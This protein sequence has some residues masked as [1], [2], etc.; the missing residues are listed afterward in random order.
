MTKESNINQLLESIV[1]VCIKQTGAQRGVLVTADD[2]L[3]VECIV[4]SAPQRTADT[5]RTLLSNSSSVCRE[6][7]R[8]V[9]RTRTDALL[10]NASE[11]GK[12]SNNPYIKLGHIK[13]V[14][15]MPFFHNDQF[16][17]LIYLENN[18]ASSAFN[19]QHIEALQVLLDEV[20]ILLLSARTHSA[21][22]QN[23][24]RMRLSHDYANISIWEWDINSNRLLWPET[25]SSIFGYSNSTS[26]NSLKNFNRTV[27]PEDQRMV[28]T[29]IA[30]SIEDDTPYDIEHRIMWPDGTQRWVNG[31]G[32]VVR[33]N[34]GKALRV[35]GIARDITETIAARD[36]Q[37]QIRKQLQQAQKL[38]AIGQLTG[39]I[40]HDFNNVLSSILGFSE[41]LQSENNQQPNEKISLY[42]DEIISSGHRASTIIKQLQAFSRNETGKTSL[43]NLQELIGEIPKLLRT[44]IPSNIKLHQQIDDNA[45][46]VLADP[47][48]IRQ[49][50]MNL[51][52]NA[53]EATEKYGNITLDLSPASHIEN[54][55]CA[56][57]RQPI[58]GNYLSL[59][60][61]NS[62]EAIQP[63]V[64]QRMFDPFFTTRKVG[65]GSGMGLAMAHGILHS[66]DG[67]IVVHTGEHCDTRFS[68]LFPPYVDTAIDTAEQN[69]LNIAA[70]HNK[71]SLKL[72]AHIMVVDDEHSIVNL[73]TETLQSV[74]CSVEAF[75]SSDEALRRFEQ[76]PADFDLV[77]TDQVMPKLTGMELA[78]RMLAQRPDLP[79]VL[80]TGYSASIGEETALAAGIKAYVE[81]PYSPNDFIAAIAHLLIPET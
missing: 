38:E 63:E 65:K 55:T 1:W 3:Y 81:K 17:G 67:H 42:I 41:L 22:L 16:S 47:A 8:Y 80:S 31:V 40:A 36:K 69:T 49:V 26:K 44:T 12:Y 58:N 71:P 52:L 78:K 64:L 25:L 51:C 73:L 11:E 76:S 14:L 70:F 61:T 33:D 20:A 57:C 27:H 50:L 15:C 28:T 66:C 32:G 13:S 62:G 68:L 39:G 45:E 77:I 23:E 75:F 74:G 59:S 34:G 37:E 18:S 5:T 53:R 24:E 72:Q 21:L 46:L 79:I 29:A 19:Q 2:A 6:V 43:V 9:A 60:V 54:E 10:N 56:S 48:Q 30:H 7:I 4:E 35:V